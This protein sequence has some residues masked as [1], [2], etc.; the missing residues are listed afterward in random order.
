[1][2]N[3]IGFYTPDSITSFDKVFGAAIDEGE[4]FDEEYE[5]ITDKGNQRWIHVVGNAE[6][7]QGKTIRVV[8]AYQDITTRKQAEIEL[9]KYQDRLE[10]LVDERTHELEDAQEK[11]VRQEK[12]AILGQLAGGVGHELRNPLGAIKNSVYYLKMVLSG[13]ENSPEIEQVLTLLGKEIASA[14]RII[15]GLLDYARA[16]LPTK[17]K[18]NINQV[19]KT[20]LENT[21]ESNQTAIQIDL[22][23]DE[24][25]PAIMADPDQLI[26]IFNNIIQNGIQAIPTNSPSFT[27]HLV[28]RTFTDADWILV[29]VSDNG[30]GISEENI[31][32]IFEP[33][34][35]T[36]TKGIGLGMS[37]VKTLVNGHGGVVSAESKVG[38][39]ST[40]TVKFPIDAD[41]KETGEKVE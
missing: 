13:K 12:L 7:E 39:G 9:K 30:I 16:K 22:E 31:E 1:L 8:G 38:Q 37:I 23:L 3:T 27:G 17:Q 33:L 34:F 19:V 25:V 28:I 36:K 4:P 10:E 35:T 15:T 32:K 5:I 24:G 18:V 29:S 40:M 20:A 21:L 6:I 11:L 26:Q 41:A 14:E 2:T